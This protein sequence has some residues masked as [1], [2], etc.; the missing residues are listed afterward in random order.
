V[1]FNFNNATV[2]GRLLLTSGNF[3]CLPPEYVNAFVTEELLIVTLRDSGDSWLGAFLGDVTLLDPEF[4]PGG[5]GARPESYTTIGLL[6]KTGDEWQ[7]LAVKA[8][9]QVTRFSQIQ[10]RV[11]LDESDATAPSLIA[12]FSFADGRTVTIDSESAVG[13]VSGTGTAG[14]VYLAGKGS[15]CTTI[16]QR[17]VAIHSFSVR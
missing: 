1:E 11:R 13:L 5:S 15:P 9:R 12:Q 10:A 3:L 6:A 4:V 17:E 16:T 14:I 8:I 2:G 7:V